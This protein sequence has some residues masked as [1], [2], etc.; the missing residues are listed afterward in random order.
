MRK[1]SSLVLS[2]FE[3][4]VLNGTKGS[5]ADLQTKSKRT[6]SLVDTFIGAKVTVKLP[7]GTSVTPTIEELIVMQG[8]KTEI[9]KSRGFASILD[10]QKIRGEAVDGTKEVSLSLVD[11]DL[12]ARA[13]K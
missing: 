12:A 1:T 5:L 6:Q 10:L 3:Q 7:D 13:V 8:L 9:I 2:E 11:K 4:S